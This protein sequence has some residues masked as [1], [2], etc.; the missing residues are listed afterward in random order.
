MPTANI[1]YEGFLTY[2]S[3]SLSQVAL[4][5]L[6]TTYVSPGAVA[7]TRFT[8]FSS[9][10]SPD[11]LMTYMPPTT[12]P[13]KYFSITGSASTV[14]IVT[15]SMSTGSFSGSAPVTYRFRG[16]YIAGGVFEVWTS[17]NRNAPPP[18]GHALVD[19]VVEVSG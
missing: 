15:G 19:V 10:S 4:D 8:Y 16:Y 13:Y 17:T 11:Y 12:A 7:P 14:L 5:F 1:I 9:A 2:S 3:G 18:S 6:G